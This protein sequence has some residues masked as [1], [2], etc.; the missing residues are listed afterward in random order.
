VDDLAVRVIEM[1]G[2]LIIVLIDSW[3]LRLRLSLVVVTMAFS[4]AT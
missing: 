4:A 2:L 1:T 3:L